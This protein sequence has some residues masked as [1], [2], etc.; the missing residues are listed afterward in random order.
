MKI[1]V[2]EAAAHKQ[3]TSPPIEFTK[4]GLEMTETY[5]RMAFLEL[6][7]IKKNPKL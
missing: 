2:M 1:P 6:V 7:R 3:I 4:I 5:L